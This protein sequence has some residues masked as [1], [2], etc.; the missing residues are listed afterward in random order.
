MATA[1]RVTIANVMI[2]SSRLPAPAA[3]RGPLASVRPRPSRV[4]GASLALP[5]GL[6][7]WQAPTRC[8]SA[9][10]PVRTAAEPAAGKRRNRCSHTAGPTAAKSQRN[11]K[12]ETESEVIVASSNA[13]LRIRSNFALIWAAAAMAIDYRVLPWKKPPTFKAVK[14]C[15]RKALDVIEAGKA[16]AS[17]ADASEKFLSWL[18]VHHPKAMAGLLA[19]I[20]PYRPSVKPPGRGTR[21]TLSREE[22][23]AQDIRHNK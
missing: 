16:P 3:A 7:V 5:G 11:R 14:K 20:L 21:G 17:A 2:R 4:Q 12:P 6:P 15:L 23:L 22:T 19:R 9:T 18:R 8:S 13:A 1:S 10:R